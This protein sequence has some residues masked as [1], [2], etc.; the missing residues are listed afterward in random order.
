MQILVDYTP[1][2][3]QSAGIGRITQEL[4]RH[5]P[6]K[7]AGLELS[8][9]V[10]GRKGNSAS[11]F[12][13]VPLH[14]TPLRERDMTRLWHRADS[15]FPRVEWFTDSRPQIFHATDFVLPPSQAPCQILTVHD[16]AFRKLSET[17]VPSLTHYLEKVVPRSV[18]RADFIIADSHSTAGDLREMWQVSE[19]RIAVVPGGVDLGIF[20]RV[21]DEA[22]LHEVRALYGIGD[23][24]YI[25][26]LSTLQPRKN[27]LRLI[28][29]FHRIASSQ[30]DLLL[31]IGGKRGWKYQDILARVQELSLGAR[32]LFPGFIQDQH[33]PA[34]Y[35][36]AALFAYPSLYEGFGMPILEAMACGTPV[37]TGNNSSLVESGG[38]GALY[39]DV[40]NVEEIAGGLENIMTNS[41]LRKQMVLAG[42]RHVAQMG[43]ERSARLLWQAYLQAWNSVR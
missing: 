36:G 19:D 41:D 17:A 21:E 23:V 2:V 15:P 43:W 26:G 12:N 6:W 32:V 42:T 5:L 30:P 7:Q 31:V 35:S 14:F 33:L 10:S 24:P 13:G 8:L 40:M 20:C 1:A 16:L 27:F 18:E 39:V 9:F 38:P 3:R 25:L 29:S 37:L 4:I 28:E 22:A 34:L 11:S